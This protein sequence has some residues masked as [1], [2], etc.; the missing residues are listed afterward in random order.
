MNGPAINSQPLAKKMEGY[1]HDV[2]AYAGLLRLKGPVFGFGAY[3]GRA[4]TDAI[5]P[6]KCRACGAYWSHGLQS[7]S[8][9]VDH[10]T[11]LRAGDH[12]LRNIFNRVALPFLCSDC[13]TSFEPVRSPLCE[14]CGVMFKSP[15]GEDHLCSDC[16][17]QPD[18][19]RRARAA[20]VYSGALMELVH[21]LKYRACFVLIDPLGQLLQETFQLH[22]LSGEID[23]VLPI[24]LHA[25]RWRQRGFNQAQMLVDAWAKAE[26]RSARDRYRFPKARDIFV[27]SRP[28]APQ[29]GLGRPERRRNIRGA[30]R[31]V[32]RAAVKGRSIL[33]VDD[34]Y[35]T[36][37]TAA[38]AARELKEN[39]A[40]AVDVLTIARTMPNLDRMDRKVKRIGK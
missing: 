7:S 29:T 27:R 36:G 39:G 3:V 32:D 19:F 2:A 17:R 34:V 5:F 33:L 14:R 26:R 28:T 38:E 12:G 15:V 8:S 35:T 37:A 18:S 4:L 23:M 10:D 6:R 1:R 13:L 21:H 30:F 25:R 11:D 31:V 40:E 22:W 24:P 20:G 9:H 16:L